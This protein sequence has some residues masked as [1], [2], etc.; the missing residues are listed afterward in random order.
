MKYIKIFPEGQA[1]R[2]C[3]FVWES[4]PLIWGRFAVLIRLMYES[5]H[6]KAVIRQ[7]KGTGMDKLIQRAKEKDA[8]AFAE[9]M[10]RQMQSMYKTAWAMVGNDEDVA[11]VIQETILTCYEKMGQLKTNAYF[12]TWMI[13][14]L[15]NKCND[16]LRKRRR[17]QLTEEPVEIP[18]M[19]RAYENAEWKEVLMALDEKYR[20]AV[21]L[22]YIEGLSTADI[23]KILGLSESAVRSRLSRAR[24]ML[25]QEL[26]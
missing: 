11:D 6:S 25:G 7:K 10:Q 9:L 15:I 4:P 1:D 14:I 26:E 2:V 3:P 24:K 21:L 16:L 23:S 5:I 20:V 22:Y 12:Q 17:V 13:R 8:D 19:E 18:V